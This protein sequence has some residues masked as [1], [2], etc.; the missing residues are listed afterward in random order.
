M[1]PII[2]YKCANQVRTCT[3]LLSYAKTFQCWRNVGLLICIMVYFAGQLKYWLRHA[4]E[5]MPNNPNYGSKLK[6]MK[7]S[8]AVM[9]MRLPTVTKGRC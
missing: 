5:A 3:R 2:L 9:P 7:Y 4:T 1:K 6:P 8:Y